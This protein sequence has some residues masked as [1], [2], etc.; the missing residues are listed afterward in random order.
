MV[1]FEALRL[2]GASR[3]GAQRP[4]FVEEES[5]LRGEHPR[6]F[7]A[8]G[9][10][11]EY[12]ALQEM[13]VAPWVRLIVKAPLQRLRVD[14]FQSDRDADADRATWQN[15]WQGN[16]LDSAQRRVY[17]DG[18]VH[19]RG[20]VFVWA[21]P[22]DPESPIVRHESPANVWVEY[23]PVDSYRPLW[24]YK[25][26]TETTYEQA[27]RKVLVPRCAVY[28]DDEVVT[29]M[30]GRTGNSWD[31]IEQVANPLGRVP[32][33]EFVPDRGTDNT[34][35]SMIRPLFPM[36]RAID[37]MRFN[38][39]IA[40]QFAA[41]RQRV[42]TG[43][44]P[45]LRDADGAIVYRKDENGEALLDDAGNPIPVIAS[46]GRPGVDRWIVFPGAD[47]KVWDLAESNLNNYVNVIKMLVQQ[48]AAISQVP[49]QY[50]LG[51]M[52]NLSGDALDAAESTLGSLVTDLKRE[53]GDSWAEVMR[54]ASIAA[55]KPKGEGYATEI[56]WGD[57][58]ARSF[59]KIVDGITKLIQTGMPRS[60]AWSMLPGA[61]T[62][63]VERWVK[64]AND[65]SIAQYATDLIAGGTASGGFEAWPGSN[66]GDQEPA[67][68]I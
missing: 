37:T 59:A 56:I 8:E 49:P 31:L 14:G 24:A 11:R 32:F 53:F 19:G 12:Y 66:L 68:T 64:D 4:D 15:V 35:R 43:Y 17:T 61:T 60:A 51:D 45:R 42:V 44:D 55:G 34:A 20:V 25:E 46:P 29:F 48:L 57:G 40:A 13:S 6:P 39:L 30:K 9:L 67:G 65:E 41:Y 33:V 22:E 7:A 62:R 18:F 10:G 21:N 58:E 1:D 28:T 26:W 54:L 3:L 52:A 5:Y 23:D 16:R 38:L 36:Q 47:T 50:L 63:K 2:E 27:G